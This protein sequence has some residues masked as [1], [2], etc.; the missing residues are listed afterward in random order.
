MLDLYR[1]ED[2]TEGLLLRRTDGKVEM[3]LGM[4]LFGWRV[5][6][7]L[8]GDMCYHCDW[9]CG[10]DPWIV[11]GAYQMMRRFLEAGVSWNRLPPSS[12]IKPFTL[13][14]EFMAAMK[15]LMDEVGGFGPEQEEAI[16]KEEW[17]L[18]RLRR[19]QMKKIFNR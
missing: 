2:P 4:V 12:K 6:A 3:G 10:D 18:G 9:C 16:V 17:D 8:V 19:E 1:E 13:D 11:V 5:R 15:V 14:D 7:G